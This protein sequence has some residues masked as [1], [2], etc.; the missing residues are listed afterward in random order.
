L[1]Y[2]THPEKYNLSTDKITNKAPGKKYSCSS[3]R[4]RG[5]RT[6]VG[7]TNWS[8]ISDKKKVRGVFTVTEDQIREAMKL[9][10]ERMKLFIEPSAA[11]PLA[12]VLFDEFRRIAEKEDGARGW[13]VGVI[14]SGENHTVQAF[15][16]LYGNQQKMETD[17]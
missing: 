14:L 16:T 8:V 4:G 15:C 1:W 13:D 2:G 17:K 6:P 3:G 9:V 5:L 10:L 12:T 7:E 11:V